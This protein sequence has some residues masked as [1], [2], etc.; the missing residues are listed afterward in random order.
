MLPQF[1][2][3]PLSLW[4]HFFLLTILLLPLPNQTLVG[5]SLEVMVGDLLMSITCLLLLLLQWNLHFIPQ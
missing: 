5:D 4:F 2:L 3:C 1:L